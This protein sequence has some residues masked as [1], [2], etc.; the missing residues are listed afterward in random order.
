MLKCTKE[1]QEQNLVGVEER[2][3]ILSNSHMQLSAN[4]EKLTSEVAFLNKEVEQVKVEQESLL[5]KLV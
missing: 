4:Q 1:I 5:D 3:T 2:F